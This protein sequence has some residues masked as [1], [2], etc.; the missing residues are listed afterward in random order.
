ML[1]HRKL[2]RYSL[3]NDLFPPSKWLIS[4]DVPWHVWTEIV[5]SRTSFFP[6]DLL[7]YT[8]NTVFFMEDCYL[9]WQQSFPI[10]WL[11]FHEGKI[12]TSEDSPEPYQWVNLLVSQHVISMVCPREIWRCCTVLTVMN[13]ASGNISSSRK[14]LKGSQR[15]F[16]S[17]EEKDPLILNPNSRL[18][19]TQHTLKIVGDF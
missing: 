5:F 14:Y 8:D 19:T 12:L 9:I 6:V 16:S 15:F 1:G 4:P 18:N 7:R 17:T 11:A 2:Y 3:Q 13:W 10:N